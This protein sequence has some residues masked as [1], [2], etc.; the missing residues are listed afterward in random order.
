M[1]AWN[2]TQVLPTLATLLTLVGCRPAAL[3]PPPAQPVTLTVSKP[4]VRE[5]G[6][7]RVFTGTTAA[8]QSV[9]IQARVTGYLVKL[10]FSEGGVVKSG[11]LL[12]EID[13]RPYQAKL[14]AAQGEVTLNEAQLNLAQKEN[15]RAKAI[16]AENAGAISQQELDTR[17]AKVQE[18][19][20]A[21]QSAKAN[22]EQYR[23]DLEFTKVYSPI[24]G[25]VSRYYLTVGNLVTQNQTL[26][27]TVVS[28]SPIYA[29]FDVDE[30]TMLQVLRSMYDGQSPP[31]K[32]GKAPVSIGLQDDNG[33]SHHGVI[34]FANNVVDSS[35][36]T[37]VV[38]GEFEN[39][40]GAAGVRMLLPGMFVRVKLPVGKPE[41]LPLVAERAVVNDQGQTFLYLVDAQGK[42]EYR[43]VELGR[44]TDDGLWVVRNGL[45]E[46]ERVVVSGV[47]FAK[48]GEQAQVKEA[49][50]P[51]AQAVATP[52]PIP[53]MGAPA[54][55]D[56]SNAAPESTPQPAAPAPATP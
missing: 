22:L 37:I 18:A 50:M 19:Q 11:E 33:F 28:Q 49:P 29:Y 25:R 12:A 38:R 9:D 36:G 34:D 35:T 45:A 56:S 4:I 39:P 6:D 43:R 48:P 40:A 1:R 23:L 30:Q 46:G 15:D 10:P 16:R 51:T 21:V 26:I 24:D 13:P 41:R 14:D 53:A 27:T 47:Q 2:L 32:S 42:V 31:A 3:Q 54:G 7:F 55:G 8:A 20:A 17:E 5:V 44:M 52:A